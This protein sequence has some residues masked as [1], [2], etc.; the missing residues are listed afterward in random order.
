MEEPI[1]SF[2]KKNLCKHL[3]KGAK[4]IWFKPLKILS[5]NLHLDN[6]NLNGFKIFE[7][8]LWNKQPKTHCL[9]KVTE[10]YESLFKNLD[11]IHLDFYIKMQIG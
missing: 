8:C 5:K 2:S 4:Q 1:K 7:F 3:M 6:F 10:T 9:K 11:E